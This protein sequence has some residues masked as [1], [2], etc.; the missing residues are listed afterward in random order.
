MAMGDEAGEGKVTLS[1]AVHRVQLT[2]LDGGPCTDRRLFSAG[3]LLSRADYEDVVVERGL[4][5]L[6]GYPPC[7]NPLP[8]GRPRRGRYRV[9]LSE[10]KVFD[11]EETYKFCSEPCVVRSRAFSGS[12]QPD[13]PL[14]A[15]PL[16]VAEALRQFEGLSSEERA[17]PGQ[18]DGD[19]GFS[20]L[21]IHEKSVAPAGEVSAEEWIGPSNAI[22]GYVPQRDRNQGA[23]SKPKKETKPKTKPKLAKGGT[24]TEMKGSDFTSTIIVGDPLGVAPPAPASSVPAL[25][26]LEQ[27]V[28]KLEHGACVEEGLEEPPALKSSLKSSREKMPNRTVRW[29]DEE[30]LESSA[31]TE[32]SVVREVS[33]QRMVSGSFASLNEEDDDSSQ[34]HASAEAC[35]AALIQ[36][37]DAV[38]S[39]DSECGNAATEAGVIILPPPHDSEERDSEAEEDIMEFDQGFVKWP[40]KTVL[41]DSDMFEV[42]DSWHDTPPEGFSLTLS[43]F[44]TMWNA[45]FGWITCSSL[46]FVYGKEESL[47]DD[48]LCVNGREYPDKIVLG[49]GRSSEIKQT[50]AGC[51][52]RSLPHLVTDLHLRTPVSSIEKAMGH[53]LETMSFVDALPPFKIKQWR[54]IVLLFVDALSV[55]RIPAVSPQTISSR[56]LLQKVLSAAQVSGEEYESMKDILLPLGR[57]PQF[58]AQ[59]GG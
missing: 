25:S 9:S 57:V 18:E 34:R 19:F 28:R 30:K 48:F 35:V 39:G 51:I 46:A 14:S 41:L 37:A 13:R 2:L 7:P 36:A 31:E 44:A 12:L 47:Q 6:C 15:G 8:A 52:A 55:H 38:A 58:S 26:V 17:G 33:K 42:E 24:D 27:G 45:L 43:P 1:G 23:D 40:K 22:E 11:L 3:A 32:A 56:H 4:A 10:H 53:L 16:K 50:M 29:A 54:V 20:K 5:G 21:T 59:S 49:D